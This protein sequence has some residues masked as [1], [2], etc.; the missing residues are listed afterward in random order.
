M[1]TLLMILTA[2]MLVYVL[3]FSVHAWR[4]A[5]RSAAV[6]SALMALAALVLMVYALFS[7]R[8]EL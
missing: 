4:G 2:W 7:G 6:G 3:S 8:F 1:R 5:N